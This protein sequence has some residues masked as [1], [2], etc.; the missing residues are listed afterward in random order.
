MSQYFVNKGFVMQLGH[1]LLTTTCLCISLSAQAVTLDEVI[2]IALKI[3]PTLRAS[4][5]NSQATEENI[6]LARAKLLPQVSL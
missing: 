4:K 2:E 5:L 6:A 1:R 3:D